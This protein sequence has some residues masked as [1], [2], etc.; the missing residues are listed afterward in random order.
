MKIAEYLRCE[1]DM[2]WEYARQIGIKYAVGRM[3]D[4]H[5][6]ETAESF[7][8]LKKMKEK[9]E[10]GGFKLAVIEP[11]PLNQN[12]K[13]GRPNRDVEIE[14]MCSLIIHMGMLGIEVL[15]Y[16]F[17]AHF[18]WLRT[19]RNIPERGGA[20]VTGYR[21]SDI[22]H[23]QL[24]EDGILTKES[25]WENFLYLQEAIVP[26]AEQAGVRLALHPDDPPVDSIQQIGR[27]LTSNDAMEKAV[28]LVP[29][30]NMGITMCQGS[31]CAMGENILETIKKFGK[32]GKLN[33]VHFRDISGTKH[34]F[35]ETFHD[36][37]M[38]DMAQCIL[39]YKEIGYDGYVRVDHVP[40]LAGEDNDNP[41]YCNLGRL[42]AVGYL[43]GLYEMSQKELAHERIV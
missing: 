41:G 36:N 39:A 17:M 3:P 6:E 30:P 27:I 1:P 5:M 42:F 8:L 23:S 7:E 29:S 37:G 16:N 13:F 35:H 18:G 4:G 26:V 20:L 21:H 22:D 19:S 43:K 28:N 25:L 40:T 14:R 2:Q 12:I 32:M 34:D 10:D 38:T 15:C 9:Y 31:F 11:A 24:T 33:F